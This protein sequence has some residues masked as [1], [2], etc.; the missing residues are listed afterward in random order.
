MDVQRFNR[1]G[2]RLLNQPVNAD[3]TLADLV[4]DGSW[5]RGFIDWYLVP[6]GSSIWSADPQTFLDMPV[7]TL[8]TF[9]DRHGMLSQGDKPQWRTVTGGSKNYVD[10]AL[11]P[12]RRRGKLF[13]NTRVRQILR[14]D[15]GVEVRCATGAAELFD[16]VIVATHSDQALTLLADASVEE[17][18]VLGAFQYQPNQVTLH[19]D[20]RLMPER[21]R[22][23][24]SWNYYR[25]A[26]PSRRVTMTYHL[27]PLQGLN[28]APPVFV[29]LNRDADIAEPNVIERFQYAHPVLNAAAVRAQDRWHE[30]NGPSDVWFCGAYWRNGF[31]EDG[32]RSGLDVCRALGVDW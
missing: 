25:P 12:V 19:T 18:E 7:H 16:R 20:Q 29:T 22:A 17:K 3:F 2:Q 21:R 30:V 15:Q 24:A 8:A 5:S 1:I 11:A 26:Q 28:D 32:I 9:F 13:L 6:L 14:T 10:A 23:W 31:H 4:N 27:N